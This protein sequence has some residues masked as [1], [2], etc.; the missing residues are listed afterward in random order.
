MAAVSNLR[1]VTDIYSCICSDSAIPNKTKRYVYKIFDFI[2]IVP[3][4]NNFSYPS[5]NFLKSLLKV[6]INIQSVC[7]NARY[8]YRL[9]DTEM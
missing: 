9:P 1:L 4:S 2:V 8:K 6:G 3:K 7:H 5:R